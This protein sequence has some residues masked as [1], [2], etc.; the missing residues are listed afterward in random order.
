MR[1]WVILSLSFVAA[2]CCSSLGYSQL[3]SS[4]CEGLTTYTN[5]QPDDPIF[6]FPN[7]QLGDLTVV[8]AIAGSSFNF[9][10]SRF[11][12]GSSNWSAYTTQ[13]NQASSTITGLQPGA[14]F[15]SIRN[16]SNTIVGCYRAWI[17]QVIQEPSVDVLPIASNCV[18]PVNLSATF[19]P[20][21]ITPISNLPESQLVIDANTQVSVCFSG[22]HTWVSDLAFHLKGPATCGSPDILLMANPGAIGQGAV[23][24]MSDN[25]NNFCFS[26][27]STNNINVCASS[28]GGLSGTYGS[29]GNT[30]IPIN[31]SGIYGCDA[32]NGGW[33]V[34]IFDCIGGDTG[35]LTDA[36]ITFS[37]TDLC[38]VNQN[39]SYTTPP[40][41]SS[42]IADNSCSSAS[43]SSFVVSPAISPS[44]LNCTFGYEWSSDPYVY[45]ADSTSSL[46]ITLNSLVDAQG[47]PM[48][49]QNVDFTLDITITCDELASENDCFGGNQSDTETYVNIPLT[50]TAIAPMSPICADNGIVQLTAD[51]PGGEWS[52]PGIIDP[53]AGQFDPMATGEGFFDVNYTF[54]DPCILPSTITLEVGVLPNLTVNFDDNVC[55]DAATFL[56]TTSSLA[57]SYFG[58]GIID[59][60]T[61][62]F[63]PALAGVGSHDVSFVTNTTCP[64]TLVESI[65]VQPLPELVLPASTDVCS[66]DAYQIIAAGADFYAWSPAGDLT[67][68]TVAN[69][70]AVIAVTTTFSLIGT[71][72]FGCESFADITLTVPDLPVVSVDP[73]ST[74]C[75]D[76]LIT[77]S[78]L[79]STG[80][81]SWQLPSGLEIGTTQ[82]IDISPLISTD[83][84]VQLTDNC[85][86]QA[87]YTIAVP[88]E[89]G[90]D[91]NAGND[92]L[93]CLGQ[94]YEIMATVDGASPSVQWTSADGVVV[95]A[96]NQPNLVINEGGQY[97]ITIV[98]P[99]GC[100]YSD[101]VVIVQAPLPTVSAGSNTTICQ[102]QAFSLNASGAST[103]TWLPAVGL[104]NA[105]IAN[106]QVTIN[107]PATYT[108][109]GA[110][111]NGC[112]DTTSI[113]LTLFPAPSLSANDVAM[114]CP[115][116][117]VTLMATGST[118]TYIWSPATSLNTTTGTTVVASPTVSMNYTVTL[119]DNCGVQLSESVAVPVEE[120][121][122]VNAGT[123]TFFCEGGEITAVAV[124]S[125]ANAQLSWSTADGAI[126]GLTNGASIVA[127]AQGNY[128]IT[129]T[130]PLQCTYTDYVYIDEV[131]YANVNM[132]D[133]MTFCPG[134]A[135]DL[136]VGGPWD[137]VLWSNGQTQS[138]I[139][140]G[141]EG[142]YSVAVTQDGCTISDTLFVQ[143]VVLPVINLGPDVTF[144]QGESDVITTGYVGQ[145]SNGFVSDALTVTTEGTYGFTYTLDGCSVADELDVTIIPLPY[146]DAATTQ[147]ACIGQPYTI[148]L[149]GLPNAT[150]EWSTGD[151]MT[152]TIVDHPG[153]YWATVSNVCGSVA[154]A[155]D[156]V[157]ED[158]ESAVYTP[159]C[160]T[161]DHDGVND[162][163]QIVTRN[164]LSLQVQVMNR[165]GEVVFESTE[166]NPAWTGGFNGSGT[167]VE[168]GLYF[169][170]MK[171]VKHD[172]QE[173]LE[174]GSMFIIR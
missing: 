3:T 15:V 158:C 35:S 2:L 160:F 6:Y 31:W 156:V 86:N 151:H 157:F 88:V 137:A 43:A 109:I 18:G 7:G 104:N 36:T 20:G 142:D 72:V 10:W 76:D 129:L 135:T 79:G 99:L 161:P 50:P 111:N 77:L 84:T 30:Q 63:D 66:S 121:Y 51:V 90:Y 42:F 53:V 155:I 70:I 28:T 8:P 93:F 55:V 41:Y 5:G 37:G 97:E 19:T 110:D 44:T 131:F 11:V 91:V 14:Y 149:I 62:L 59:A 102:N 32:M 98:S 134:A 82:S 173:A 115:S 80:V 61:G 94:S 54:T 46:N 69:P 52:G 48:P 67:D 163:W 141:S 166:L 21:Q 138:N 45:I 169:Y 152:D 126:L 125:G 112:T 139:S 60:A 108:V 47:N 106:P 133:T 16:T 23:C 25:I 78:A 58:D 87:D 95:G 113:Q 64:L 147:F 164:I 172:G 162:V 9:V 29:Y 27:E 120:D 38:G 40:G 101:D 146:V 105:S 148:E 24:N 73:V 153:R 119:T 92:D 65:A 12:P 83:Y 68:A 39:V 154:A 124:I 13:N 168:D 143:R 85:G 136:S 128:G 71:S 127:N 167:Y 174:E 96:G 140:V 34:Q 132:P 171:Y 150:Y 117:D 17:A 103:Y 118:G 122:A 4:G 116:V 165:W 74:I 123:D 144:C 145:W 1:V 130:S 114:I 57:G 26:T 100:N 49:W 75:P 89:S 22:S 33:T 56:L 170:R 159:N 107:A 81:W